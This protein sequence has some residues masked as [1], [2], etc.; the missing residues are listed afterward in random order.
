MVYGYPIVLLLKAVEA[1][2]AG[3]VSIEEIAVVFGIGSATLKRWLW[4]KRDDKALA[5]RPY[6]GGNKRK[7][8]DAG[9][10]WMASLLAE[11]CD[12]T[13]QEWRDALEKERHIGLSRSPV[14]RAT[15][16]QGWR[17]RKSLTASELATPTRLPCKGMHA[18]RITDG[19]MTSER[20]DDWVFADLVPSLR[21]D[22]V[23]VLDNLRA[24][25]SRV[26]L[27]AIVKAGCHYLHLPPYYPEFNPIQQAWSQMKSTLRKAA[28]R[29]VGPLREGSSLH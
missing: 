26:A 13:V 9:I 25:H 11:R 24:H 3:R 21:P 19:A 6:G 14:N 4:R 22:Q 12:W 18:V 7:L 27:E 16:K 15:I 20:F 5:P 1:Y 17:P 23:V 28:L 10:E 29:A 8:S 2:Q